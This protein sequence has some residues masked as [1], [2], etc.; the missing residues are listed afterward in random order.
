MA[1]D[2]IDAARQL[3]EDRSLIA[4]TC[5]HFEHLVARADIQ[6]LGHQA[7]DRGLADGLAASDGQRRVLI[8]ALSKQAAHELAPVN[9]FHCRQH[10]AVCDALAAQGEHKPHFLF[11]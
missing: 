5:A 1:L 7:N 4:R 11:A 2:R 10:A 8:G 9:G 6:C 3:A